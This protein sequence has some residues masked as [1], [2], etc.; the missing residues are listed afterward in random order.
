[1]LLIP[2]LAIC[3]VCK[4]SVVI[5]YILL[6]HTRQVDTAHRDDLVCVISVNAGYPPF[7]SDDPLT[8]CRKIVNWR[9]FLKFPAEVGNRV[10]CQP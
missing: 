2:M 6:G 9:L 1:M 3:S 7:Y 10:V 8:T 4:L 5:L